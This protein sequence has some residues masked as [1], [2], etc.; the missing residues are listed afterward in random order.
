[1][2]VFDDEI[3]EWGDVECVFVWCVV[4]VDVNGVV[5]V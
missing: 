1:M 3:C 2:I 5:C 4:D